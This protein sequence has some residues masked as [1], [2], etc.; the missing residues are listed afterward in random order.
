MPEKITFNLDEG[1][2]FDKCVKNQNL[3]RN[4]AL[5]QV[6]LKRLVGEFEQGKKYGEQEVN[7][8]IKKYFE[9]F[10]LIRREL[11]NFG[12]MQ[13]DS[14]KGEYWVVKKELTREDYLKIERLGRHAAELGILTR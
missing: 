5:K 9:D 12:Y 14:L 1:K 4:D 8:K 6:I 3:P 13:R 10:A 2:F 11:I 7:E